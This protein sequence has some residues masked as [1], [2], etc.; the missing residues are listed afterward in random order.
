MYH[1]CQ[2]LRCRCLGHWLSVEMSDFCSWFGFQAIQKASDSVV[3]VLEVLILADGIT[4]TM[5][6]QQPQ[7]SKA[8]L[9]SVPSLEAITGLLVSIVNFSQAGAKEGRSSVQSEGR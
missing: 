5:F 2:S 3:R 8:P 9:I 6:L 4:W 7:L 1:V